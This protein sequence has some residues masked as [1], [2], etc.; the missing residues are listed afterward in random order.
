MADVDDVVP[1][2]AWNK[3]TI[4]LT[5]FYLC[6]QTILIVAHANQSG[7]RFYANELIRVRV[8]LQT[9]ISAGG[10]T[11]ESYLQIRSSP[12]GRAEILIVLGGTHDV[13][14][15]WS[16][17][18]IAAACTAVMFLT[19][20]CIHTILLSI[21]DIGYENISDVVKNRSL[22]MVSAGSISFSLLTAM[23]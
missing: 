9:D 10:N 14:R 21:A 5:E 13:R 11:H 8:N 16:G 1:C 7:S 12:E 3:Q 23:Q 4:S 17:T 6:V 20:I 19:M 2:T 22:H 15:E 18:M